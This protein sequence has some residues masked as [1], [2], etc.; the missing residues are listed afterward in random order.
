MGK[1]DPK[2]ILLQRD[3]D[4]IKKV[5]KQMK[6]TSK[7]TI[8]IASQFY[9]LYNKNQSTIYYSNLYGRKSKNNESSY[10][11]FMDT[12]NKGK[13]IKNFLFS[14]LIELLHGQIQ[15]FLEIITD[16]NII[17][18]AIISPIHWNNKPTPQVNLALGKVV[19]NLKPN[20]TLYFVPADQLIGIIS[21]FPLQQLNSEEQIYA[22]IPYKF[23]ICK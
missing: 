16:G 22:V 18:F 14:W 20:D 4:Q 2:P 12:G 7:S 8:T 17:P 23:Q 11:E 9:R 15:Y 5:L 1:R 21:L 19:T 13:L 3:I 6:Y 10:V